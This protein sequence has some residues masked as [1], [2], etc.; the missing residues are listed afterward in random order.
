MSTKQPTLWE[1]DHP[2]DTRVTAEAAD[3]TEHVHIHPARDLGGA[4]T[5]EVWIT[6]LG[7]RVAL[8]WSQH[9]NAGG[10][11]IRVPLPCARA[12]AAAVDEYDRMGN[13]S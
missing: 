9:W 5:D 8:L 1:I 13:A 11:A 6:N 12:I 7:Q 3:T 4:P 10:Y 2:E